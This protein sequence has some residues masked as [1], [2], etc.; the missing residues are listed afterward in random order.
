L[1]PVGLASITCDLVFD[2]FEGPAVQVLHSR[3]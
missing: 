3:I 1:P 2:G